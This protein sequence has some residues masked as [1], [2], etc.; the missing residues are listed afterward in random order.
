MDKLQAFFENTKM[1]S[2]TLGITPLLYGS[3]GLQYRTGKE[4][5]ADDID[6]LIPKEFLTEKW[7]EFHTVLAKDGY[8]LIDEHEHT[9]EKEGIYYSYAQL[10]ELESFAGISLGEMEIV[11][12]G[13]IQFR[14]LSLLQYL[15]VYTAS[16]KDGYRI[17]TRNKKDFEKITLIQEQLSLRPKYITDESVV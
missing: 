4:L 15:K 10:E 2:D 5:N 1:L 9:F 12:K 3:L 14:V 11:E 8:V 7:N 6:I 13:N 16:S 17:S